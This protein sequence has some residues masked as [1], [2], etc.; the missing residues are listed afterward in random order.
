MS[1]RLLLFVESNT[2]GTGMLALGTAGRLGFEPVFLTADPGRY[3]GLAETG[4]RVVRCDTDSQEELVAAVGVAAGAPSSDLSQPTDLAGITTTSE[5]FLPA[6]AGLA[7]RLGLPGNPPE[8][9]RTCR[10]KAAVRRALEDAGI[11]QPAWATASAVDQTD[12]AL[13]RT[14]LPCVVKPVD[15]SGS[16]NVRIC[17]DPAEARE[18]VSAVLAVRVNTRGQPTAGL[19]LIEEYVPGP[20]FSVEM[21]STDGQAHCVGVTRKTVGPPPYCV[22]TGHLHPAGL[23]PHEEAALV[24][25]TRAVLKALGVL[26]GPTHTEIKLGPAG[27]ALIEVN[28]RLAGGMIPDLIRRARGVDLLEQQLRCAVGERPELGPA[29]GSSAVGWAGIRF[30]TADRP[31]TLR[32]LAGLD[33]A[34]E[35]PG[36]VQATATARPGVRVDV[37]RNAYDRLGFVI[38]AGQ[39]PDVVTQALETAGRLV[40]PVL[41]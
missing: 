20:E 19:A 28:C 26:T 25:T 27:P 16:N 34:L 14:G 10:D 9:V 37:P 17:H 21:F 36:V 41:D 3:A 39:S 13:A 2:T 4:A 11:P 5:F 30:L 33:R 40:T 12:A 35:V 31:G 38:A 6:V 7:E 22:E 1:R 23:P 18:A 15:D 8:A 24:E 32:E 29:P